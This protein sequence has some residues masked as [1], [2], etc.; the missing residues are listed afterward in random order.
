[1]NPHRSQAHLRSFWAAYVVLCIS[2]ALTFCTYIGFS[3]YITKKEH[4]RFASESQ[5]IFEQVDAQMNVYLTLMKGVRALYSGGEYVSPGTLS[6]YFSDLKIEDLQKSSGLEGI[7]LVW[8]VAPSERTEHVD[9]MRKEYPNYTLRSG[10]SNDVCYPIAHIEAVSTN[11][12]GALGWDVSQDA[13]RFEAIQRARDT[14]QPAVTKKTRILMADGSSGPNGF[15]I[16]LPIYSER[17]GGSTPEERRQN[18][19]GFVYGTFNPAKLWKKLLLPKEKLVGLEV[20]DG[21]T[22]AANLLYDGDET[23]LRLSSPPLFSG[24][25]SADLLGRRW[26]FS[27]HSLPALEASM[28]HRLPLFVLLT[29]LFASVCF[30]GFVFVPARGKA[31]AE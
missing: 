25:L 16:Y 29:G 10:S 18:L 12:T 23:P 26:T 8:V 20:Y 31:V 4:A 2:L 1:M 15:V 7:G 19:R 11:R 13:D 3:R 30:F 14:G 24:K 17:K 21:D 28:E 6:S 22:S 9:W 27:F 5:L